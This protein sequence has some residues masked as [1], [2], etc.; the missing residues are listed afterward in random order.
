MEQLYSERLRRYAAAMRNEKPDR[1]PIRPFVAEFASRYAGYTCQQA[2]HDFPLALAAA[3]QCAA[4]FDWDATVGNMIYVWTGLTEAIGLTYYGVPGIHVPA[5]VGFQYREPPEDRAN[6][7]PD[8]YDALIADPTGFLF[9]VWLPR[10]SKDV[11]APGAPSTCRNNLSFLKG[12]MAM[13]H[14]FTALGAQN[15][16]LKRECGVAPAIGGILKAPLDILGDKLRGYYGLTNDL[17]E[18][19]EKVLA[20]CQALMPHLMHVALTSADPEKL[21]P[22]AIWMHRGCVPF[23][24]PEQFEQVYWPTLRPIVETLW[25]RGYQ[26]LFYAEGDW[27]AHLEAFTELPAGSIIFHIDRT[28]AQEAHRV[29]HSRFCL[30]GG[31][32][33]TLLQQGTPAEVRDGCKRLIDTLGADG[34]YIMDASA[35]VQNDARVENLRAM[36]EFTREYGVY[37]GVSSP[38][39]LPV[40]RPEDAAGVAAWAKSFSWAGPAPGQCVAW[41]TKRK[42]YGAIP[43]DEGLLKRV[44]EDLEGFGYTYI[45][46]CLVSF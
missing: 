15:E 21:A 6:M 27:T 39:A 44:W 37:P 5:E 20:A 25:A 30:S 35:I 26:V 43:G 29:L 7:L 24:R 45:W 13:L 16:Q 23:V 19:P 4:D 42:E 31:L 40:A 2:T 18:Q 1:V 22:I 17:I 34:G 38:A 46:H 9:N 3:R 28:N 36:T 14:Y 8:E 11:V 12:G 10:V 33:N 32:S 41:E